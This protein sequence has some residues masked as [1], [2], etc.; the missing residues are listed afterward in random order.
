MRREALADRF[1]VRTGCVTLRHDNNV[2]W[3]QFIGMMAEGLA[4]LALDAV[5]PDGAVGHLAGYRQSDAGA[6][7][8]VAGR[9]EREQVVG[10]SHT[11]AEDA[12][13]SR[14]VEQAK[15]ARKPEA[16]A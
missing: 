13:E 7:E 3:R 6:I 8:F 1:I 9:Q 14:R 2:D 12:R 11:L 5:A 15:V 10:R 4:H 16:G